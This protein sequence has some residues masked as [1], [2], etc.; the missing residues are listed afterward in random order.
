MA[1]VHRED[2]GFDAVDLLLVTSLE[3]APMESTAEVRIRA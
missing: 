2:G 1:T 3:F